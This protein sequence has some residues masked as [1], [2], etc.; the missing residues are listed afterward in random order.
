MK[1]N[2]TEL[3]DMHPFKG[4]KGEWLFVEDKH[5]HSAILKYLLVQIGEYKISLGN[6]SIE[7]DMNDSYERRKSDAKLIAAVPKMHKLLN[8]FISEG[9]KDTPNQERVFDITARAQQLLISINS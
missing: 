2:Q 3:P 8:E 9:I 1:N 4:T 5:P 6:N 7:G